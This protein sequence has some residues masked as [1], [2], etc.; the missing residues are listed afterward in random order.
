MLLQPDSQKKLTFA[1]PMV[2]KRLNVVPKQANCKENIILMQ[3]FS[4]NDGKFA[5]EIGF[6][7]RVEI[8]PKFVAA[9]RVVT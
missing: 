7:A 4:S 3:Y 8:V 2:R 1:A 9:E 6:Y 5:F